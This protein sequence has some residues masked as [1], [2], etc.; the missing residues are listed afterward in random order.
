[1]KFKKLVKASDNVFGDLYNGEIRDNFVEKVN[2][3]RDYLLKFD[4][5][6]S[7]YTYSQPQQEIFDDI[8]NELYDLEKHLENKVGEIDILIRKLFDLPLPKKFK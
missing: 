5:K 2:K 6:L 8:E 7:N 1:M 4:D 3:F